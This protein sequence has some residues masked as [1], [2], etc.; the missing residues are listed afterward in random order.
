M[1]HPFKDHAYRVVGRRC[2]SYPCLVSC[3]IRRHHIAFECIDTM[4]QLGV[5]NCRIRA[6]S[7]SSWVL[8]QSSLN[9]SETLDTYKFE[10]FG[11]TCA[12][13]T[14]G[15]FTSRYVPFCP[16]RTCPT[17]S[18]FLWDCPTLCPVPGVVWW[19]GC[20]KQS[21]KAAVSATFSH[22]TE[23]LAGNDV[24]SALDLHCMANSL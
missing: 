2:V 13:K 14:V 9:W 12:L 24:G 4:Q 8:P 17:L 18:I 6:S 20:R 16:L 21:P 10:E 23:T 22:R 1:P 19:K 3:M 5:D 7:I 11:N 15:A